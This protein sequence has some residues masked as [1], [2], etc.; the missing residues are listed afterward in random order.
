MAETIR[1][2]GSNP[3]QLFTFENLLDQLKRVGKFAM[4]M[5]PMLLTVI[6]ADPDDIP[7]LDNIAQ[8]MADNKHDVNAFISKKTE[9]AYN[10]R[11]RDV[12]RDLVQLG[13]F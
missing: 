4:L 9:N 6:T 7:D 13:Y 11:V 5:A 10:V 3:D 12:V 8:D 2:L 1:A